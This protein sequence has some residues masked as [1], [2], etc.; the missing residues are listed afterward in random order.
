[1]P[2]TLFQ[3][4]IDQQLD[5]GLRKGEIAKDFDAF[6][7]AKNSASK[8]ASWYKGRKGV[9]RK[10]QDYLRCKYIKENHPSLAGE[11]IQELEF[12]VENNK[13]E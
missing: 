7:G 5:L 13:N 1:M 4:Y 10:L 2:K 6:L 3:K 12:S 11:F 8:I 9:P